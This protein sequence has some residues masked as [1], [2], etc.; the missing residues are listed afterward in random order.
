MFHL[1]GWKYPCEPIM[2]K[3]TT[4]SCRLPH[5]HNT[6][7]SVPHT[8]FKHFICIENWVQKKQLCV[9]TGKWKQSGYQEIGSHL[10]TFFFIKW[11]F[12]SF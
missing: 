1:T 5:E 2:C 12:A 4:I 9:N 11:N 10:N 6:E 8:Y 3:G 7:K